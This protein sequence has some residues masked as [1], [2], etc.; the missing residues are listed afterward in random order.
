MKNKEK[1]EPSAQKDSPSSESTIKDLKKT[2]SQESNA[3][4]EAIEVLS[5]LTEERREK[6]TSGMMVVMQQ[7]Y[8]GPIPPAREM[9][10]YK[11][12]LPDAPDR[13]LKMAEYEQSSRIRQKDKGMT[14]SFINRLFGQICALIISLVFAGGAIYL[15][16]NGHDGLAG[17]MVGFVLISLVSV[18]VI[19]RL[20]NFN[21]PPEEH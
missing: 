12:A 14:Y 3:I 16:M 11:D 8:R 7:S 20:P 6:L 17:T 21:T 18:F 10:E 9:K 2:S 4:S 15:G 13:I 19:G 1:Q 5:E